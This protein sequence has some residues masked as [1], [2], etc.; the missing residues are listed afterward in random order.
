MRHAAISLLV[1]VATLS[2]CGS[3][4]PAPDPSVTTDRLATRLTESERNPKQL[5]NAMTE[6]YFAPAVVKKFGTN[7]GGYAEYFHTNADYIRCESGKFDVDTDAAAIGISPRKTEFLEKLV[8]MA[9]AG[10]KQPTDPQ[11]LLQRYT[12][13]KHTAAGDWRKWL[14][15]KEDRLFFTEVGGYRWLERPAER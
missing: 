3:R 1:V 2:G 9:E 13:Q 15:A 11:Q 6:F 14:N 12:D 5:G 7:V 4:P 10:T 8:S